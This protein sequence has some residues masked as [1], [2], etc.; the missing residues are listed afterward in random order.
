MSTWLLPILIF[1]VWFLWVY[2]C[3]AEANLRGAKKGLPP[4]QRPGTSILPGIPV[5]PLA[6]WGIAWAIDLFM[7]PWGTL[8][9]G[10]FHIVYGMILTVSVVRCIREINEIDSRAGSGG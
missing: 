8:A 6:F 3:A 1:L 4:E 5:F 10:A 9:V 2:V 7:S